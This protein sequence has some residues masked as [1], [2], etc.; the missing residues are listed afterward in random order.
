M[1]AARPAYV[2]TTDR[3]RWVQHQSR[4]AKRG[5]SKVTGHLSKITGGGLR[6]EMVK[7]MRITGCAAHRLWPN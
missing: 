4:P 7:T 6:L 2:R 5:L 1:S 3:Y